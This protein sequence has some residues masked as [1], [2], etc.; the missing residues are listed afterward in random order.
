VEDLFKGKGGKNMEKLHFEELE[1][2]EDLADAADY[3]AA[4]GIG[5]LVGVIIYVGIAT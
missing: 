2:V 3:G 4:F 5:F 1:T